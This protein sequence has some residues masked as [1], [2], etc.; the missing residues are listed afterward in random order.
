[1]RRKKVTRQSKEGYPRHSFRTLLAALA[2]QS[3][4]TCQFGDGNAVIP[5]SKT[6][7]PSPLQIEAFRLLQQ[8][9]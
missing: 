2:T 8:E 1:V 3:R 9:L 7:D 4:N 5:I 6:T